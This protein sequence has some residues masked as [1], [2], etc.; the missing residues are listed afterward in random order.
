MT[1]KSSQ[2]RT[3]LD[4]KQIFQSLSQAIAVIDPLTHLVIYENA[5]FFDWFAP[6]DDVDGVFARFI[7]RT[8]FSTH[9]MGWDQL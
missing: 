6:D 9:R 2:E 1:E 3:N 5:I 8:S 7:G 4:Y